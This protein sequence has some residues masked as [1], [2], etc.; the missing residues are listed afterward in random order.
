MGMVLLIY[1]LVIVL[2]YFLSRLL[3]CLLKS[4][5]IYWLLD[6]I[7]STLCA[8]VE[9]NFYFLLTRAYSVIINK[10]T[11]SLNIDV[12]K[13]NDVSIVFLY[14][15]FNLHFPDAIIR[16]NDNVF[17]WWALLWWWLCPLWWWPLESEGRICSK[18]K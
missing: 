11:R 8:I 1:F 2:A 15:I 9:N 14:Y 4:Y 18:G 3:L 17:W 7:C 13:T 16:V 10:I 6:L 12:R 5:L